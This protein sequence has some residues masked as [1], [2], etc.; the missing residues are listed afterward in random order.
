MFQD[1]KSVMI[2][3]P[4]DS[5]EETVTKFANWMRDNH[6]SAVGDKAVPNAEETRAYLANQ[7]RENA[8]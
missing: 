8:C 2:F 3:D 6:Y 7:R 5:D 1:M 4:K